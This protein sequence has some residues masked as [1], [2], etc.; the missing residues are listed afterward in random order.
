MCGI[1][2]YID[3]RGAPADLAVIRAMTDAVAHR[4][5]NGAD[6]LVEHSFALGHRRLSV[7]DLSSLGGQPMTSPDGL[8]TIIFNGE[9]YNFIEVRASLIEKGHAFR[10]N[11]DTEVLLAAYRQ[12]GERCVERFNGMWAFAIIDR[13][14]NTIFLSRDRFG[15]KPLYYV[16]NAR[17][18][19]FGSEIRQLLPFLHERTAARDL[20]ENFL[21]VNSADAGER[22]FFQGVLRLP[23]GHSARYN[24]S[25]N[26]FSVFRHYNL[27]CRMGM[28]KVGSDEL[29]AQFIELFTDAIRL[30]L[31]SDVKVGTCLSGG[32]D[33]SSVATIASQAYRAAGGANFS[34]IT[35]VSELASS[36]ESAFAR[37]VVD[38][39]GL[40]WHQVRPSYD[41]FVDSLP[42]IVDAQ[43]EPFGSPSLT[44]QYF[45]MAEAKRQGITVLLDGQGGDET[46]LGYEKYY[47][48]YAFSVWRADGP[49]ALLRALHSVR[50]NNDNMTY[51][52]IVKYVVG[53][54]ASRTRYDVH[55]REHAYLRM[56]PTMPEHVRG[57]AAASRDAFA[58]QKLEITQTNLPILLRYED[59]N[60]MHH[61]IEA[62]L[63][64]L[65]YR[66][67]EFCLSLPPQAKINNGWTKWLLRNA[68]KGRMDDQIVWRKNKFGFEA[69]DAI[70]LK[71]HSGPMAEA[72]F[73]S[74]LIAELSD[75]AR[76][77]KLLPRLSLRNRWRLYSLALWERQFDITGMA[78]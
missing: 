72:I 58:L 71:E 43:E 31:R 22:T 46:L 2:G 6:H 17:V 27:T 5:P 56:F 61:G 40:D 24:L 34:A 45:V 63:P 76:L 41:D 44:M 10:S 74:H 62:R 1:A 49:L 54:L 14:S 70:W 33:S 25:T 35:A 60:S 59:K 39:S 21:L 67:V 28:G 52:S 4:G 66:L 8:A 38:R 26:D 20:V 75:K 51:R 77:R 37:R 47:A 11:S 18:F 57:F 69:P 7:L 78:M 29:T 13:T 12:W 53:G 65:D 15:V 68:M 9:I 55:K 48:A 36:D 64:F 73:S 23:A 30:R 42:K 16:A 3:R 32:L 50:A 19:A